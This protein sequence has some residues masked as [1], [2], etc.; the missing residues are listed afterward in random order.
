M[1]VWITTLGQ[2]RVLANGRERRGLPKQRLRCALLIYLAV[3][4]DVSRETL[5]GIFWPDKKRPRPIL[6][7]HL[8]ELRREL[9]EQVVITSGD[10]V[11]I[12]DDVAVDALEFEARVAAGDH[13]AAF[14]SYCGGF[15]AGYSLASSDAFDAWVE[16]RRAHLTRLHRRARREHIHA[17]LEAGQGRTALAAAREWAE[18]EPLEDEAQHLCI[19]LLV[20]AGEVA[21]ARARFEQYRDELRRELE[22]SPLEE[23]AALFEAT[24]DP[25][26]SQPKAHSHD[27][28]NNNV[29]AEEA[30][31]REPVLQPRSWNASGHSVPQQ[32]DESST[33]PPARVRRTGAALGWFSVQRRRMALALL[34]GVALTAGAV[35]LFNGPAPQPQALALHRDQTGYDPSRVIVLPF[36]DHSQYRDL[37]HIANGLTEWLTVELKKVDALSVVSKN[38]LRYV[39]DRPASIQ[40]IADSLSVGSI[41]SGTLQ[42][43]G[44]SLRVSVQLLDPSGG[45]IE[46][47]FLDESMGELFHLLDELVYEVSRF[48]R[49]RIGR[50]IELE[51]RRREATS[52]DAWL[53]VQEAVEAAEEIWRR[54]TMF[55]SAEIASSEAALVTAEDR[56]ERAQ[57]L[58]PQWTEPALLRGWVA[59]GRAKVTGQGNLDQYDARIE[60]GLGHVGRVIALD[61]AHARA[62]ELRGTLLFHRARANRKS[63]GAPAILAKAEDDLL[64]AVRLDSKLA[65]AWNTLSRLQQYA[66]RPLEAMIA[67]ERALNTDD[68]LRK[69]ADIKQRLWRIELDLE[70][71]A[72]A[73]RDCRQAHRDHP[74]DWRFIDCHLSIAALAPERFPPDSAAKLVSRARALDREGTGYRDTY[75]RVQLAVIIARSRGV[76]A[77]KDSLENIR[78][79]VRR[80][81]AQAV[82]FGFDEAHLLLRTGDTAG[83]LDALGRY[84]AENPGYRAYVAGSFVFVGLRQDQRFRELTGDG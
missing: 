32:V 23:T 70:Q 48:L 34:L 59:L 44:D 20:R 76:S 17:L 68:Y 37:G 80:N 12:S 77:A 57:G 53:L 56:L 3:E 27:G 81:A 66:G 63:E 72:D 46:A 19:E 47:K 78:A 58:D 61:S 24:L 54:E 25:L 43:S 36:E 84:L 45:V 31:D 51:R 2:V 1:S 39:S 16:R 50:E 82:S 28:A 9:G 33:R 4:R 60:K 73:W 52:V 55:I 41:V 35:W 26:P 75:R 30:R 79:T 21:E 8:Y 15:L 14:A 67:V 71:F 13:D 6:N 69:D 5:V 7:Q 42:R 65:G 11:Q 10:R 74:S 18:R 38:S 83:A 22:V 49:N 62:Y 64:K 29:L 40:E